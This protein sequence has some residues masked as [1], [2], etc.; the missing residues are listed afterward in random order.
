MPFSIRLLFCLLCLPVVEGSAGAS[1]PT[2]RGNAQRTG[3]ADGKPGPDVPKVLWAY[4][5]KDHFVASPVPVCGRVIVSGLGFVNVPTLYALDVDP[6]AKERVTW[7]KT[8]PYL[9]HPTVSSPAAVDGLLVFG[10]GMHQTDGASLYCL[11]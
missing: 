5:S 1:W 10:D 7:A 4:K 8:S 2:Y 6:K 3:N 11:K 9:R